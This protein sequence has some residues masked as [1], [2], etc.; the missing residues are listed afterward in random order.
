MSETGVQ[1]PK[2]ARLVLVVGVFAAIAAVIW[3]RDGDEKAAEVTAVESEP[4]SVPSNWSQE[5]IGEPVP[6]EQATQ[7]A[8]AILQVRS[9]LSITN[10]R[11]SNIEGVYKANLQGR[12]VFFSADG[13]F[14]IVGEMYEV[15]GD[16]LVNLEEEERRN[17]DR[18]FAP[19]RA[20]MLSA[21]AP[22]QMVI[23][24]ATGDT[25]A[26]VYV[27]TDIDCGYCRKLHRQMPE[28]Q[29]QGIEVRYLAFPRAGVNSKSADKLATAWCADDQLAMMT[30]FKQGENVPLAPCEPNPVAEQ[31]AL[32]QKVGVRGTPAIVLASGQ[33]IPGAVSTQQLLDILKEAELYP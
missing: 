23:F 32:G 11:Y 18:A 4:A 7:I 31:Y 27:F 1:A 9:D 8:S 6:E 13:R 25:R 19:E 17:A 5:L 33:L 14:F 29:A 21:V 10:M 24:P 22:E 3:V 15:T 16:S 12:P 26:Q 2:L 30:R 20:K 28:M